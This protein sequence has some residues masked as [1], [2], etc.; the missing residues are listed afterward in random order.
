MA[1]KTGDQETDE[2]LAE[3][4]ADGIEVPKLD[5]NLQEEEPNDDQTVTDPEEEESEEESEEEEE[6]SD[7]DSEEEDDDDED[8][9]DDEEES[10]EDSASTGQGKR[11]TL[12][13]KY[14]KEKKLRREAEDALKKATEANTEEQF[15]AEIKA[16]ADKNNMNLDVAKG[17]IELAA[18]RAGLPNDVLTDIQASRKERRDREY[19]DNQ[20]VQFR[21]DFDS[22]VVPVLENLGLKTEEIQKTFD[23][24]NADEKSPNWAWDKKNKSKSLV[25]LALNIKRAGANR[26]SSE[27]GTR[28]V[29]TQSGK[30]ID[31][32]SGQD[33]D[34]M[35]DEEFDT[36][37]DT[38]G[39]QARSVVHSS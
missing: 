11:L 8:S 5:K 37:S 17:I 35:S 19:W 27:G 15:D 26:T 20:R 34:D 38:L 36:L 10:E 13:E 23:T 18:K 24:L 30:S 6:A 32:M 21:K 1:E 4:E 2:I 22:N 25:Q 39:K 7:D 9:D 28:K 12:V 31:E 33:I 29:R 3:M 14:R 16:F